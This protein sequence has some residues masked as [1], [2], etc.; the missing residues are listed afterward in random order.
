MRAR[1]LEPTVDSAVWPCDYVTA[2]NLKLR[3]PSAPS[4][5]PDKRFE[6]KPDVL[7]AEADLR[8]NEIQDF[9]EQL[10]EIRKAAGP[11]DLRLR[12]KLELDGRGKS[13]AQ[14]IVA[15]L[16]QLLAKVSKALSF[17]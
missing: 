4:A 9:A 13:P 11:L 5:G 17:K 16:N 8:P 2:R 12:L 15:K 14:D 10:V 3:L 6:L 7:V 1:L